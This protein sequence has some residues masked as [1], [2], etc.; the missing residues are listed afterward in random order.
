MLKAQP[1]PSAQSSGRKTFRMYLADREII[2]DLA[3]QKDKTMT[4]IFDDIFK[5]HG[6]LHHYFTD[7]WG[8]LGTRPSQLDEL[9]YNLVRADS[10]PF[11]MSEAVT[12]QLDEILH[13]EREY[14]E[15]NI[16]ASDVIHLLLQEYLELEKSKND[17][18][19]WYSDNMPHVL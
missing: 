8:D 16:G 17:I 10:A 9:Q 19:V 3:K 5:V 13:D 12:E 2:R 1:I 4:R 18:I 15:N 11:N 14:M 6:K 7:K